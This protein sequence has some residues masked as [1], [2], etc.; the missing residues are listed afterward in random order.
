MKLDTFLFDKFL[1]SVS[2]TDMLELKIHYI[3]VS[4]GFEPFLISAPNVIE[5][6]INHQSF[7]RL[8]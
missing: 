4:I 8:T 3:H 2:N 6:Y 1:L 7:L 5:I